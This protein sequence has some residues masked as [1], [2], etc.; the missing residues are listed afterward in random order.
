MESYTVILVILGLAYSVTLLM[1]GS[2]V[3][4]D[5]VL[6]PTAKFWLVFL[7]VF[8]PIFGLII[9]YVNTH[10]WERPRS[11][12]DGT[13]NSITDNTTHSCDISGSSSE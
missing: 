10:K 1:V 13:N 5:I 12:K 8:L 6:S 9:A 3:S 4:E 11:Y 7:A 2:L